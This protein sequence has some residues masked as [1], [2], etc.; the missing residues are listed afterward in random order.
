M[1]TIN[2]KAAI[3]TFQKAPIRISKRPSFVPWCMGF[4]KANSLVIKDGLLIH[5]SY[6]DKLMGEYL[7]FVG[8]EQSRYRSV[9]H[10]ILSALAQSEQRQRHTAPATAA[11][12]VREERKEAQLAY[13]RAVKRQ[14]DQL[15]EDRLS[16]GEGILFSALSCYLAGAGKRLNH[17]VRLPEELYFD[18]HLI[19]MQGAGRP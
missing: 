11:Q 19:H 16:E 9:F 2:V 8:Q 18:N 6:V 15:L 14:I 5:S 7:R 17:E 12:A 13:L 4:L 10:D 3:S 1:E